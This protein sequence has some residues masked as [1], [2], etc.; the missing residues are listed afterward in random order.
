MESRT[1]D[2]DPQDWQTLVGTA[3]NDATHP[4][5]RGDDI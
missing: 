1:Q 3:A 4:M 2:L 5:L